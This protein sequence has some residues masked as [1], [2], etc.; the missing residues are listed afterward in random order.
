MDS[1]I[2]REEQE[3]DQQEKAKGGGSLAKYIQI[4]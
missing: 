1:T 4:G 2:V 3:V